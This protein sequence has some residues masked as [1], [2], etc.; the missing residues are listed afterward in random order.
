MGTLFSIERRRMS[1]KAV[2]F[3][4]QLRQGDALVT[5]HAVDYSVCGMKVEA[6]EG[7]GEG[8]CR[9]EEALDVLDPTKPVEVSF[10]DGRG[11]L[12]TAFVGAL[13]W[14]ADGFCGVEN[15][16]LAVAEAA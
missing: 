16:S 1:R 12:F 2:D 4:V 13:R 11:E 7:F 15:L 10:V 3:P 5:G 8:F 6:E 14:L 9:G